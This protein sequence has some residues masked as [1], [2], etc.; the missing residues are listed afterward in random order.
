M[1]PLDP[2]DDW[3]DLDEDG[4]TSYREF[5]EGTNPRDP[6]TDGDRYKFDS[7]DPYPL[8]FDGEWFDAPGGMYAGNSFGRDLPGTDKEDNRENG[9]MRGTGNGQ[10]QGLGQ[11]VGNGIGQGQGIGM[12]GFD[13]P[14]KTDQDHDGLI[15]YI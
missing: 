6:N 9:Q 3:T 2:I 5:L 1:D 14:E 11:G 10:G 4:W 15:E 13:T 7:T 8:R 12:P